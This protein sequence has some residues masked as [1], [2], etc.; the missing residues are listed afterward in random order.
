MVAAIHE[1]WQ[2]AS[3][4]DLFPTMGAESTSRLYALRNFRSVAL[5]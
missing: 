3:R 2:Q 5:T 1:T 4:H